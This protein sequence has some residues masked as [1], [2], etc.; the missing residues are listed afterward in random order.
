LNQLYEASESGDLEV[1]QK[2]LKRGITVRKTNKI[3]NT[4]LHVAAMS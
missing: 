2:I 3:D 4:P 1:V